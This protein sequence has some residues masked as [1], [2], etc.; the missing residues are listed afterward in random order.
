VLSLTRTGWAIPGWVG[1]CCAASGHAEIIRAVL[2]A[3]AN[4][5]ATGRDGTT[6]LYRAAANGHMAAVEAL[7]NARAAVDTTATDGR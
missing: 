1:E 4:V 2:A 5:N 3:G 6:A 7:L